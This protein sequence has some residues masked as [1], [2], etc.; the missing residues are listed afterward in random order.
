MNKEIIKA[1]NKKETKIDKIRKWWNKNGYKVMRI[2][3][4]P[5]WWCIKA[6]E[7]ITSYLNSKCEWSEERANEILSYYIPR[8]ADWNE[9]DKRFY[10]FDNGMGWGNF[11]KRYLKLKDRRWWNNNSGWT[12]GKIRQ[13][14]IN[15]YEIAGFAKEI[16]DCSDGRTEISFT[17]IE[18]N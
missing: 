14:L 17:M 6:K 5:I 16:G 7:K 4:F 2:I 13:Y 10:F 11:A 1:M 8:K 12:G 9:N 15:E 3:L 18:K